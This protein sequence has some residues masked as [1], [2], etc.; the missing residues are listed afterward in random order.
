MPDLDHE[1]RALINKVL[2]YIESHLDQPLTLEKLAKISTYSPSH[3]HRLF[4]ERMG[5]T[6]ADYVKRQRLEKAAHDLIYEPKLSVTEI[7]LRCGF[8]SLSYFATAFTERY[9]HSPRAWREGT[10][11]EKFPRRYLHGKKS[12]QN[13]RNEQETDADKSYTRFQWVDL[14]K[15]RTEV[16]PEA[17]TVLNH[18]FGAYTEQLEAAWERIY[19]WAEARDFIAP[20][21]RLLGVPRNNPY[22]TP[23]DK[24]RYDCCIALP[25][26]ANVG[27]DAETAVI[28]GGKFV[29]YEFEEPIA[30]SRRDLLIECYSELYSFWLPRSG[31]R[32][33]GN[34]VERV[35]ITPKAGTLDLDCRITAI[36]L[37]IDPK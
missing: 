16:Y 20:D 2:D 18:R 34:P 28:Q 1:Q 11:L 9:S 7:A 29:V 30:Y 24:C 17:L 23:M 25:E 27:S 3:F 4:A 37:P 35:R 22:L 10:Y 26:G 5:E 32:Y 33:L 14:S 21:T 12:K 13:S 8:S 15:V 19:R 36:T 31:Y 6:P